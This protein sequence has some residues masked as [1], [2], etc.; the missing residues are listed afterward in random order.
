MPTSHVPR[1]PGIMFI[2]AGLRLSIVTLGSRTVVATP[3]VR[4][5]AVV[6]HRLAGPTVFLT[7]YVCLL[8]LN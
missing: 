2:L 7:V 6:A 4:P 1:C 8:I 5:P 3:V